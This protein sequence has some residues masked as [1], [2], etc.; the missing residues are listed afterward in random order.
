[1]MTG[2][3][4][5]IK[6]TISPSV[7]LGEPLNSIDGAPRDQEKQQLSA[8]L[9]LI[10]EQLHTERAARIESEVLLCFCSILLLRGTRILLK[11]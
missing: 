7:S 11:V 1:M 10:T 9:T 8:Q 5:S 3:S 6:A 4:D 2:S